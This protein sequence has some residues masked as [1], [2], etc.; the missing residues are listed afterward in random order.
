MNFGG[1]RVDLIA[2][3]LVAMMESMAQSLER[4][5]DALESQGEEE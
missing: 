1:L 3:D 2:Q 4:I 5:A